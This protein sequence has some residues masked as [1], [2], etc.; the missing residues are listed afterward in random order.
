MDT[1]IQSAI[2]PAKRSSYRHHTVEFKRAVVQQ[3]LTTDASVSRIAREH[4]VNANQLFT[5]RKLFKEGL[6]GAAPSRDC[7]LLP[8]VTL[9]ELPPTS[10]PL[11]RNSAIKTGAAGVMHLEV[12]KAQLRLEGSVD[13]ATL[14][15]VLEHLL[16]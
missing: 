13:T 7:T 12:G 6:P 11:M 15:L 5:W 1:I 9:A 3:S 16:R 14:A 4:N 2:R 10:S 8:V